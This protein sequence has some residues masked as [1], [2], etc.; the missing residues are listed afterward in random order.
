MS[1]VIDCNEAILRAFP[2]MSTPARQFMCTDYV[3]RALQALNRPVRCKEICQWINDN[4]GFLRGGTVEMVSACC[5]RLIVMGLAKREEIDEGTLEIP[6]EDWCFYYS[7]D[8]KYCQTCGNHCK[9][10]DDHTKL[11]VKNKVAYFSLV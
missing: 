8:I 5:Q 10:N 11:V 7:M 2:M 1:I 9:F 4:I 3:Y 6:L